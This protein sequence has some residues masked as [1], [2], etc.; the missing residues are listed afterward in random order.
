MGADKF[1]LEVLAEMRRCVHFTGIQHP[2]CKAGV[3][4][5][6]VRDSSGK[7]PYRWPCLDKEAGAREG[8]SVGAT[9]TRRTGSVSAP[10]STGERGPSS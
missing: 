3:D 9:T 6:T 4:Y 7:G 5:K 8:T 1:R 2:T 10:S